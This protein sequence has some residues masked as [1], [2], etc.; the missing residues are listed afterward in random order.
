M[1]VNIKF[2]TV[3]NSIDWEGLSLYELCWKEINHEKLPCE[4][5]FTVRNSFLQG[6]LCF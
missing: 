3:C 5:Y 1:M 4:E 2:T 6:L